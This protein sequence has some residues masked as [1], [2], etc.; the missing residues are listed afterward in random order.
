M[1]LNEFRS[2]SREE[3]ISL[4]EKRLDVLKE[5]GGTVSKD[6]KCD[7]LSFSYPSLI[8]E[9]E[10]IGYKIVDCTL[11]KVTSKEKD[12]PVY[13]YMLTEYSVIEEGRKGSPEE[14]KP[15]STSLKI[16][17]DTFY[18]FK[19]L[20]SRYPSLKEYVLLDIVIQEGL[21]HLS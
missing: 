13:E 2:L 16:Y 9:L 18:R 12:R 8:R 5:E 15:K 6:F 4:V 14:N 11:V 21:K 19:D 20:C 1:T 3:K 17:P 7:D 10:L